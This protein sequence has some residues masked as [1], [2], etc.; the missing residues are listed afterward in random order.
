MNNFFQNGLVSFWLYNLMK[1]LNPYSFVWKFDSEPITDLLF[2]F[3]VRVFANQITR[4]NDYT[5]DLAAI[6][7]ASVNPILDPWI[8]ILLRRSLFWRILSLSKTIYSRKRNM[9]PPTPQRNL[10]YLEYTTDNHVFTQLLCNAN[11][12]TQLP[13]TVTFTLCDSPT[14][15]L[16]QV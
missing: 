4:E 1:S 6:R 11:I 15:N 7:I 12:I 14:E 16:Q 3:Q 9:L 8:Y 5:A 13:A 2:L 10:L